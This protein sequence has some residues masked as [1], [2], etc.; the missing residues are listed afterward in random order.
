AHDFEGRIDRSWCVSS[1]SN[2]T[3]GPYHPHE[4]HAQEK[5]WTRD[6]SD[7]AASIKSKDSF[8]S[9]MDFPKG[10][11]AG[12]CLHMLFENL[13]FCATDPDEMEQVTRSAL[14]AFDFDLRWTP[15]VM[16]MVERT[17]ASPI[18]TPEGTVLRLNQVSRQNQ[19]AE[20]EFLFPLG[21]I[22]SAG[23]ARTFARNS[24][25]SDQ[26]EGFSEHLSELGFTRHHGMLLGF[27]DLI[28]R[29]EGRYYL[30]DWKSNFLG[31]NPEAYR[32]EALGAAMKSSYYTLQYHLYLVALH[33]YLST[34][35][36]GYSYATHFGGVV[37]AY[38]RGTALNE[39]SED[40]LGI[41]SDYPDLALVEALAS[42]LTTGKEAAQ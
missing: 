12:S 19:L 38:L 23:L 29:H 40:S 4:F 16:T 27:I 30:L 35:L 11:T 17:L 28:F 26:L 10:A 31:T 22:E 41:F 33:R 18:I 9:F 21:T 36:P 15:A 8:A 7:L 20:M 37:Y 25:E 42:Y 39:C 32:P 5:N 1:F 6:E 34:T 3:A 14:K 13:D 2:L 24:A